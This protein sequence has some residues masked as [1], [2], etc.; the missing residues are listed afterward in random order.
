MV[1]EIVNDHWLEIILLTAYELL[2]IVQVYHCILSFQIDCH[3]YFDLNNSS[4]CD[5]DDQHLDENPP[6]TQNPGEIIAYYKI[7]SKLFISTA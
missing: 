5:D 2:D 3:V 7:S 6:K 1:K 4:L